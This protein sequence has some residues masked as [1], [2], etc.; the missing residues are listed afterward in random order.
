MK[1]ELHD[2]IQVTTNEMGEEYK[3]IQKRAKE[4]PGTAGDQ[5]EENWATLFREW[6]PNSFQVVTKGRILSSEG[7]ASPQ[8]DVIVLS[9]DYPQKLLD[10]KLYL[11]GGVIAAFECKNTLKKKDLEEAFS[12]AKKVKN[13]TE[14]RNGTPYKELNSPIIYGVLAHSHVWN[15]D[16]STP[17]ENVEEAI[18]ESTKRIT[19]HPKEMIDVICISDLGCWNTTKITYMGPSI[20]N[21]SEELERIYG[22]RE[23]TITSYIQHSKDSEHQKEYFSPIGTLIWSL[24]SKF[25]YEDKGIRR[26]ANYLSSVDIE[27]SGVGTQHHWDFTKVF[28][29]EVQQQI[30]SGKIRNPGNWDE[31]SLNFS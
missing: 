2:F 9:P 4:D 13:L 15:K 12:T 1:N 17:L 29:E 27:G 22:Y 7:D 21:W 18:D 11:A 10:K 24:F 14:S 6:L 23:A 30:R 19:S 16:K 28:S 3:R 25:G 20:N 31:W 26:L 8:V 5:G